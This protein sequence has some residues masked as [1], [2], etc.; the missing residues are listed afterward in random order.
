MQVTN[1]NGNPAVDSDGKPIYRKVLT[2][3][4]GTRV[5]VNP[6]G[7]EVPLP[8]LADHSQ[9]QNPQISSKTPEQQEEDKKKQEEE[10]KGQPK[11]DGE[12]SEITP[13]AVNAT[14][15]QGVNQQS[16]EKINDNRSVGHFD[17]PY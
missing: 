3:T 5:M 16:G 10:A 8:K 1:P 4:D 9:E 17:Y 11:K 12:N 14:V 7:T 13:E 15:T 6:D 2:F